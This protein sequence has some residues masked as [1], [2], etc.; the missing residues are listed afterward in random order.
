MLPVNETCQN[1]HIIMNISIVRFI[2]QSC[3]I[4][5][6]CI[7]RSEKKTKLKR[8]KVKITYEMNI[9]NEKKEKKMVHV[10]SYTYVCLPLG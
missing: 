10:I 8:S 5:I 1:T 2:S 7:Q 3:L 9:G 6:Q 4:H